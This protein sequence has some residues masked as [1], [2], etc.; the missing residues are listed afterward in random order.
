MEVQNSKRDFKVFF[1][2]YFYSFFI[3][4]VG[5]GYVHMSAGAHRIHKGLLDPL[6]LELTG[7]CEQLKMG[8]GTQTWVL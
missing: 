5:V 6:K 1:Y 3:I 8:T 7:C 4:C 2:I